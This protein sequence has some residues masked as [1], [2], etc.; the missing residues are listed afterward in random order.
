VYHTP[1][2]SSGRDL[3]EILESFKKPVSGYMFL[4][5]REKVQQNKAVLAAALLIA[6]GGVTLA[7]TQTDVFSPGTESPQGQSGVTTG[8]GDA[9]RAQEDLGETNSGDAVDDS[10]NDSNTENESS[11]IER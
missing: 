5:M 6:V 3:G 9:M 10:M 8:A 7:A 1:Y 4:V 11:S 2:W